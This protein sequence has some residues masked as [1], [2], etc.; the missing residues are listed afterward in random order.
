VHLANVVLPVALLAACSLLPP[1]AAVNL[2]IPAT[3]ELRALPMAIVDHAGIVAGA[4][5][6]DGPENGTVH[7]I[8]VRAVPGRDDAVLVDWTGGACDDLA[9]VTVDPKGNGFRVT[10]DTRTSSDG[11]IALGIA[12]AVELRLAQP[13]GAA[14]FEGS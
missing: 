1:Q 12:R 2:T 3:A 5:A 11:C 10:L 13:V 9:T 7:G 4:R 8:G 14:A 6:V